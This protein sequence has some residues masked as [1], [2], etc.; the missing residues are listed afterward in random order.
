MG[1][2]R[3]ENHDAIPPVPGRPLRIVASGTL[4]LTHTLGLVGS[5]PA[6]ATVVRAHSVTKTRGGSA[7]TLLSLLAQFSRVDAFLVAPLG[8]NDEGKMILRDLEREGVST[9]Y[10]KIWKGTGVPS[11]WVLESDENNT[12]TVINHNPLPDISHEEFVSILGPLLAPEN[13]MFPASPSPSPTQL[14]APPPSLP[15]PS[16]L[17][18]NP[19]SP[20][21]F[22]WLHFEGRS[23]KTT[24][25]NITGLDG[26]A[27][28]R[29]W[30]SHCVFSVDVGRSKGRQGVEALIPH[31][32]VLF[33]NKH[34]A[35]ATSPNFATSPRAFLL[36]LTSIAPPHAL[37]VA[38]WGSEGA[39]VLSLPTKEYFQSSG[40]VEER[41]KMPPTPTRGRNGHQGDG[42]GSGDSEDVS[43]RSG[44]QFWAGR[45]S[46][47]SS[48]AFTA[49]HYMSEGEENTETRRSSPSYA[50][51]QSQHRAG[52]D[53]VHGRNRSDEDDNDSQ[54]TEMPEE[55]DPD[56][57][58]VD[59]VGAQD[60]FVAGMIY[61]LS[62]KITPGPPYTP[63]SGG[64]DD[65]ASSRDSDRG[66]W[67]LDECL[68]FATELSGR[69]ARRRTWDGLGAEMTRAGWFDT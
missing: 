21:P 69:K 62:R 34:Y 38:H 19:N 47:V 46:V 27:R 1:K 6:P 39:A 65:G 3:R 13:Y 36:S 35:Q 40:W 32:D 2:L 17:Q 59:E 9:R 64:E 67:R 55:D 60:A 8:G 10:C 22:D 23:V 61:A 20:A 7:S 33:L 68:R 12:R 53:Y 52:G 44:S 45:Q 54:G 31:A 14:V 16:G 41:P 26:L 29:K 30:R 24:L 63:S 42:G 25:S 37:L 58:V 48:S 15:R 11:A 49:S 51:S 18:P 5:H 4:F 66:R 28:E 56:A 43:V 57:G 50:R